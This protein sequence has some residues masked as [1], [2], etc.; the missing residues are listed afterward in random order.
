M[1]KM[2]KE[3][4]VRLRG[5]VVNRVIRVEQ[6]GEDIGEEI[7]SK[8]DDKDGIRHGGTIRRTTVICGRSNKSMC[9]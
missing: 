1:I 2:D 4:K 5:Q 3:A 8:K 7:A 6:V 9:S